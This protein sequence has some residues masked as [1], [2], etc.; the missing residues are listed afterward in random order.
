MRRATPL[1]FILDESIRDLRALQRAAADG[2]VDAIN[3]KISKFGGH[4]PGAPDP[5]RVRGAG[6]PDDHRG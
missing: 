5:R 4:H 6:H 1:P 3:V 2:A